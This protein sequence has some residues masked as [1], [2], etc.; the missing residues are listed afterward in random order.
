M[1][2]K[3]TFS[4][5]R[6]LNLIAKRGRKAANL[7]LIIFVLIRIKFSN[8]ESVSVWIWVRCVLLYK[9]H[10]S[11]FIAILGREKLENQ[12][13]EIVQWNDETKTTSFVEFWSVWMFVKFEYSE[14]V[15]NYKLQIFA[16]HTYDSSWM[17]KYFCHSPLTRSQSPG[18][19]EKF[20]G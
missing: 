7:Y 9:H 11:A 2:I 17:A 20:G 18:S 8:Y 15:F 12:T 5:K 19:L 1:F 14:L 10:T 4:L 6:N 13:A 16:L 3:I